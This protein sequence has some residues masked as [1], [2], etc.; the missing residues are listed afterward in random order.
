[1]I[2]G[3]RGVDK[4]HS[5]GL[6]LKLCQ[7][8]SKIS[9]L[10]AKAVIASKAPLLLACLLLFALDVAAAVKVDRARIGAGPASMRV[11]RYGW[12][13]FSCAVENTDAVER[14]VQLRIVSGEGQQTNIFTEGVNVPAKCRILLR[15]PVLVESSERY[16][17]EIFV[18]GRKLPS[19]R[20][21]EMVLKIFTN[22][23]IQIAIL[24]DSGESLGAFNQ[25]PSFKDKLNI[26]N[27]SAAWAP[28]NYL[29]YKDSQALVICRPVLSRLNARQVRAIFDYVA[30]GG[31]IVF[32]DPK[33]ALEAAKS[34][35]A[36]LLPL[37]PLR[38]RQVDNVPALAKLSKSYKGFDGRAVDLLEGVPLPEG[39]DALSDGKTSII[40]CM[41]FGLGVCKIYAV[42]PAET[43]FQSDKASWE[44][45]MQT[46]F[47]GQRPLP[48][49]S[50]FSATLDQ[51][52]GFKI[53]GLGTVRGILGAYLLVLVIIIVLGFMLKKSGW[54]WAAA[55]LLSIASTLAIL[56]AAKNA[57]SKKGKLM[58]SI[59]VVCPQENASTA[60]SYCAY[61]SDSAFN[62]DVLTKS[63]DAWMS[64]MMPNLNSFLPPNM[65]MGFQQDEDRKI[66]SGGRKKKAN[67]LQFARPVDLK[68]TP[69]GLAGIQTMNISA[70]SS[71]QFMVYEGILPGQRF[72][73]LPEAA[74]GAGGLSLQNW[75]V[76]SG[77]KFEKAFLML[78]NGSIPLDFDGQ[79]ISAAGQSFFQSDL[80]SK[81]VREAL[82]VGCVKPVPYIALLSSGKGPSAEATGGCSNQGR[83]ATLVPVQ[84]SGSGGKA[85]RVPEEAILLQAGDSSTRMAMDGNRLK[86][87]FEVQ[88]PSTLTFAFALP[89]FVPSNLELSEITVKFAY[90]NGGNMKAGVALL[91]KAPPPPP[92]PPPKPGKK[93]PP[94]PKIPAFIPVKGVEREP[95]VFVFTGAQLKD[96]VDIRTG[97]GAIQIDASERN[98]S[99]PESVKMRADKWSP[100]SISVSVKGLPPEGAAPYKF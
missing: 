64:G 65:A 93:A 25:L 21:N 66:G 47:A 11:P 48:E 71:R 2:V 39:F 18:D 61:F 35:L 88:G 45:I 96:V 87:N 73:S 26:V 72:D 52:T 38:V 80:I 14:K 97:T 56:E 50:G 58:T 44:A 60:E 68:R 63:P 28:D 53:P 9:L 90:S 55:A 46:L 10:S 62:L 94:P 81:G 15:A 17:L 91:V 20:E 82:E 59:K 16:S 30:R 12:C 37:T 85:L 24:D 4:A 98:P 1:M 8:V 34:P 74:L 95:G 40:R 69:S 5:G 84:V 67:P 27:F 99:L 83:V 77:L 75:R 36:G 89:G 43:N 33:G 57:A 29:Q 7:G 31:T 54:A 42:S 6:Y 70:N 86:Q 19:S 51:M 41:R 49:F 100:L 3:R 76:P 13:Q 23:V 92:Q 22:K 78:P 32:A 79:T